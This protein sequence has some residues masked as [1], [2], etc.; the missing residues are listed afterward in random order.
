MY[1]EFGPLPCALNIVSS[2]ITVPSVQEIVVHSWHFN[3]VPLMS[4]RKLCLFFPGKCLHLCFFTVLSHTLWDLVIL[5]AITLPRQFNIFLS[6]IC[7]STLFK[8]NLSHLS[9]KKA[10]VTLLLPSSHFVFSLFL[11]PLPHL[12]NKWHTLST[13]IWS[14]LALSP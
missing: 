7:F 11:V 10:L 9:W 8:Q 2:L 3:R 5:F 13:L 12:S 4:R 6:I 14:P 1:F